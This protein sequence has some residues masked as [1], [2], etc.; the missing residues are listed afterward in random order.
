MGAPFR[1]G[2]NYS[3]AKLTGFDRKLQIPDWGRWLIQRFDKGA[4]RAYLVG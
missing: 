3:I 1:A 4:V 2:K